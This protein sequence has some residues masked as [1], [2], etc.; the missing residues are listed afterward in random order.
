MRGRATAGSEHAR[1]LF[2]YP[3]GR[4]SQEAANRVYGKA[5]A[6]LRIEDPAQWK[7]MGFRL[8]LKDEVVASMDPE[9]V[10]RLL[11]ENSKRGK[12]VSSMRIYFGSWL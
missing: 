1:R 7:V 8:P 3:A 12:R 6:I 10:A 5:L 9:E 2:L 4:A 11:K